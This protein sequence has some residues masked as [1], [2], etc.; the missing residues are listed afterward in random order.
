[1][2]PRALLSLQD[3][4]VTLPLF[5]VVQLVPANAVLAGSSMASSTMM[6]FTVS[7][8]L[9]RCEN[10]GFVAGLEGDAGRSD[11]ESWSLIIH[12]SGTRICCCSEARTATTGTPSNVQLI[13]S[14]FTGA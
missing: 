5:L 7:P 11:R 14:P 6:V 2:E 9:D 12:S 1:M 13:L 4:M 8:F 3:V 10:L